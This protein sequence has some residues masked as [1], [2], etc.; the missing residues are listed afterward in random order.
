[1]GGIAAAHVER[2]VGLG[3]PAAL[4][5]GHRVGVEHA[6]VQHAGEHEIAGAVE[7]AED[8]VYPVG[9]QP[10]L[11]RGASNRNPVRSAWPRVPIIMH[12][13]SHC[14]L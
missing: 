14:G 12:G 1:M 2:G 4:R 6:V 7:D 10:A 13:M 3:I 11:R 8:R 5:L 9:L